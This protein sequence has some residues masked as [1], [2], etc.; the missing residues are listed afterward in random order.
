MPTRVWELHGKGRRGQP[1]YAFG[2]S[3]LH[4]R[5]R[6]LTDS[7]PSTTGPPSV[8]RLPSPGRRICPPSRSSCQAPPSAHHMEGQ[9]CKAG[10]DTRGQAPRRRPGPVRGKCRWANAAARGGGCHF[11]TGLADRP[12]PPWRLTLLLR[13]FLGHLLRAWDSRAGAQPHAHKAASANPPPRSGPVHWV[14][15]AAST[16]RSGLAASLPP[17]LGARPAR[18]QAPVVLRPSGLGWVKWPGSRSGGGR[19]PSRGCCAR[20]LARWPAGRCGGAIARLGSLGSG[21]RRLT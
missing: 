4:P 18:G 3:L 20:S 15:G 16:R 11:P 8:P 5:P 1:H 21:S 2:S 17:E 9:A 7:N 13:H 12:C 19:G 14:P 6:L 10:R